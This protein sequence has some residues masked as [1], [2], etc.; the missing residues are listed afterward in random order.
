MNFY[1]KVY[2]IVA[3]IPKGYVM[4]YGQIAVL[5]GNPRASRA[6]GYALRICPSRFNLPCHRVV[7]GKGYLSGG[8]AFGGM[9]IQRKLLEQEGIEVS[10]QYYVNLERYLYKQNETG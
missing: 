4:T 2:E 3:R 10:P 1:E 7:N 9:E 5:T 8:P 6:V